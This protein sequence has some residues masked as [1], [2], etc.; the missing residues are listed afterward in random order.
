MIAPII[1][2]TGTWGILWKVLIFSDWLFR[3]VRWRVKA[4]YQIFDW[5]IFRD[6]PFEFPFRNRGEVV[7]V[8]WRGLNHVDH[9]GKVF[10][11]FD[12]MKIQAK[13]MQ[14]VMG[15]KHTKDGELRQTFEMMPVVMGCKPS[16]GIE[17]PTKWCHSKK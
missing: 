2:M 15:F 9:P 12:R 14:P 16:G 5:M 4:A 8:G 17:L 11:G 1:P 6:A 7:R 3:S 10:T 13:A